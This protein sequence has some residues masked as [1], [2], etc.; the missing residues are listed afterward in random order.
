M[1]FMSF[2]HFNTNH[3]SENKCGIKSYSM[4]FIPKFSLSALSRNSFNNL[5]LILRFRT[6]YRFQ[7]LSETAERFFKQYFLSVYL[8]TTF[9]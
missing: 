1:N 8:L 3:S 7:R 5:N 9:C 2:V 4:I 6:R